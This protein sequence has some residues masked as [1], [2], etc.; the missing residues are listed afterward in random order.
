MVV[1]G[2]DHVYMRS[3][4]ITHNGTCAD[5][6]TSDPGYTR[7]GMAPVHVVCGTAG[8][9]RDDMGAAGSSTA[10]PW[11]VSME[12]CEGCHHWGY[13]RFVANASVLTLEYVGFIGIDNATTAPSQVLDRYSLTRHA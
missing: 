6:G 13:C 4:P 9:F 12:A 1:W 5:A 8:A 10:A 2:H 3:C 7:A 11:V